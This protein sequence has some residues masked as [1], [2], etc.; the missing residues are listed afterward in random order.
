M[1]DDMEVLSV[2]QTGIQLLSQIVD[3]TPDVLILDYSLKSQGLGD[4]EMNGLETARRVRIDHE[5]MLIMMLSMHNSTDI[6]ARCLEAGVDGYMVKSE[7]DF[8]IVNA[9]RMLHRSG[10]YFSPEVANSLA[11]S[12]NRIKSER[13]E[14]TEREQEVLDLLFK[15]QTATEIGEKLII[16]PR[17]V[18]THRKN[19]MRKFE[20][21]NSIK[22][23]YEALRKGYLTVDE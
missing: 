17:T 3:D 5:N 6:I 19:L 13:I 12:L 18:E 21:N 23:I 20:A 7:P 2:A 1:E 10:H 16:S 22:L 14:V 11:L 9:V 8:D 15:G 4:K